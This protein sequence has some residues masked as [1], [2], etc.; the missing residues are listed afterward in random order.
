MS[1]THEGLI[2]EPY[3]LPTGNDFIAEY[4][5]IPRHYRQTISQSM[6]LTFVLLHEEKLA[7]APPVDWAREYMLHC[8][9]KRPS[10]AKG[11]CLIC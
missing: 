5:R 4:D 1:P 6:F 2:A 10:P 3:E 9:E 7:C 8:R 11:K